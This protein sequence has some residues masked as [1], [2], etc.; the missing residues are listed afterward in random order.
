MTGEHCPQPNVT[1][2]AQSLTLRCHFTNINGVP[3]AALGTPDE[4]D[5]VLPYCPVELPRG[6]TRRDPATPQTGNE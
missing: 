4:T 5:T 3:G 2:S 6:G 1:A